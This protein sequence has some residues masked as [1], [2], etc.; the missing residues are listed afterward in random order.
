[1]K[2]IH[3]IINGDIQ[4]Q[5]E[6]HKLDGKRNKTIF[7]DCLSSDLGISNYR[8]FSSKKNLFEICYNKN[9]Y[10]I[11]VEHVDSGGRSKSKKISIPAP[12]KGISA[13][14]KLIKNFLPLIIINI[15]VPLD[16][17]HNLD[18]KNR[19]YLL[20]NCDEIYKNTTSTNSRSRWVDLD[21]ILEVIRNKKTRLNNKKNV[22]IVHPENLKVCFENMTQDYRKNIINKLSEFDQFSFIFKPEE[23]IFDYSK[24]KEYKE[25]FNKFRIL[26]RQVLI[27]ERGL[28]CE[29]ENCDIN[30]VLI[31]S[32]IKPVNVIKNDNKLSDLQ[33]QHEIKD[34]NNGFLLCPN[35]DALFDKFFITFSE[36]GYIKESCIGE[37]E[38]LKFNL[39]KK[40]KMIKIRNQEQFY[41]LKIHNKIFKSKT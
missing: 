3:Q 11:F 33:K 34:P 17:D 28:K 5:K 19:I 8:P 16:K 2:I 31:A 18:W 14:G 40:S 6:S 21:D 30:E 4:P 36:D 20:L 32:H 13:I 25:N 35:H 9:F 29:I 23:N 37:S 38:L 41:Y 15:Y 24:T 22:S 1:M 26:F 10:N 27:I 39:D 7:M 12:G